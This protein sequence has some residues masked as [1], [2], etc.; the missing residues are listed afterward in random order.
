MYPGLQGSAGS[1]GAAK[2]LGSDNCR[3]CIESSTQLRLRFRLEA[4]TCNG[5]DE[6]AQRELT[7][8][9]FEASW[10]DPDRF[11]QKIQEIYEI[12]GEVQQV[13]QGPVRAGT[14]EVGQA[15]TTGAVQQQNDSTGHA[16]K[17][18]CRDRG[19]WS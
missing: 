15:P 17:G 6:M 13:N 9:L 3:S 1:C 10:Q 5:T 2:L 8:F 14:S 11:A 18:T 4:D 19:Q 16:Q 7:A 12:F